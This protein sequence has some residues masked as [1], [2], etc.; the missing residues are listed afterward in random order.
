ML[1]VS[2]EVL[3]LGLNVPFDKMELAMD[4]RQ[5]TLWNLCSRRDTHNKGRADEPDS[6][7]NGSPV[8]LQR[9]YQ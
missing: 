5:W 4:S 3:A 8:D 6:K 2:C 9:T 1:G 7:S